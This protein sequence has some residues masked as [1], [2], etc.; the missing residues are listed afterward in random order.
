MAIGAIPIKPEWLEQAKKDA[1]SMGALRGSLTKGEGNV[2]GFI[3][4]IVV[5]AVIGGSAE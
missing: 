2:A 1:I 4:E 3:G 5:S